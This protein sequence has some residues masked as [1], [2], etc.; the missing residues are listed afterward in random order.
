MQE[1]GRN[2]TNSQLLDYRSDISDLVEH[3]PTL[4]KDFDSLRQEL[5]SPLPS[6][7]SIST[8]LSMNPTK[9]SMNQRLQTQQSTIRRRNMAAQDLDNILVQIRQKPGFETFLRAESEAYLL[10]AAQEGPI[11]VLNAT[12]L[13]SDAILLTKAGV[14]S[15]ALPHL[16]HASITKYYSTS[17]DID[18]NGVKRE[19]LEWL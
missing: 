14:R 8:D 7:E 12:E 11:V 1:L 18:D 6:M 16:S 13:R 9:R 17:A 5:D 19:L 15:I 4:A 3:H 10:S 2:I